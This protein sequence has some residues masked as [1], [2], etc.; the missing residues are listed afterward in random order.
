[1]KSCVYGLKGVKIDFMRILHTTHSLGHQHCR[2]PEPLEYAYNAYVR[3]FILFLNLICSIGPPYFICIDEASA[4]V[5]LHQCR[6]LLPKLDLEQMSN[7]SY[8]I[9]FEGKLSCVTP[10]NKC[11]NA[12]VML[13]GNPIDCEL[14]LPVRLLCTQSLANRYRPDPFLLA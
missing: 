6:P 12:H 1:M 9:G 11:N 7:E 8:L 5:E 4:V 2:V 14:G 10:R 3:P 13:N